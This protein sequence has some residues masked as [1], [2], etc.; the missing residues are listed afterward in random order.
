ML[1]W[2]VDHPFLVVVGGAWIACASVFAWLCIIAPDAPNEPD[3]WD[4]RFYG[5]S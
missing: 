2:M 1:A 5:E 4:G 3:S